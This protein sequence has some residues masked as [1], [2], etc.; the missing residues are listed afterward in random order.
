MELFKEIDTK[1]TAQRV[2]KFLTND[3][4]KLILMSGRSLTDLSSPM[5]S[6]APGHTNG[7]NNQE[8]A[9]VRGLDAE[10]EVQAIHHTINNLPNNSRTILIGL[11]INH[12][13]WNIVQQRIYRE[14]TQFS[15]MRRQALVQFAD[16]FEYYQQLYGCIPCID[17]HVYN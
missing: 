8:A 2:S 13:S 12:D 5:L 17:L 15:V 14:H 3:L 7:I 1:K 4:E 6:E 9:I 11:Y 10:R 16:S